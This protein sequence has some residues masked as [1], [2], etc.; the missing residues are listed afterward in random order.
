MKIIDKTH[1]IA[2]LPL[3][4]VALD[5]TSED[6]YVDYDYAIAY[7]A[8]EDK[9]L[10]DKLG[11]NPYFAVFMDSDTPKIQLGYYNGEEAF[12]FNVNFET[13]EQTALLWTLTWR[14]FFAAE[15]GRPVETMAASKEA[16]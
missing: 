6:T 7:I 14:Y 3:N 4:P 5:F 9:L 15:S 10:A 13:D 12:L 1:E 16:K 8:Y 11:N 2:N